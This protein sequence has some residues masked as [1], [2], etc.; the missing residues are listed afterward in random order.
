MINSRVLRLDYAKAMK[1][2][3]L[4][5]S[6]MLDS[7]WSNRGLIAIL[8]HREVLH[9]YRGSFLGLVWS[10]INPALTLIIYTFVFTVVFKAKWTSS[11]ESK[12]E[13]A[14]VLFAGLIVFTLLAEC[15]NKAPTL[16][17]SNANYVKKVVFPLEILPIVVL[18][19]A[20]FHA[21]ISFLVWLVAY[22]VFYG[23]PHL[24]ALLL[25]IAILPLL[26][27]V[28]GASWALASL[29][30]YLRDTSQFVGSVISALMFVSPIFYPV[31]ALPPDYQ[32]LLRLNPITTVV[33]HVREVLFWGV[34]PKLSGYSLFLLFAIGVAWLGFVWFQ[35]TRKG[36]ADVI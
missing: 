28:L 24:T 33:E 15:L 25:P 8:V 14:L 10:F 9:R 30:V 3:A 6:A 27:F 34:V 11:S 16:I 18:G 20:L 7:I 32:M 1:V 17:L 21:A 35:S 13:F 29:G 4:S 23:P 5:P 2:N 22:S 26:C 19:S 36:F 31:S 12:T